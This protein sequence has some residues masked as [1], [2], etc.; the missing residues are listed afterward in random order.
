MMQCYH[1]LEY[2][3]H[4]I[5]SEPK[6]KDDTILPPSQWPKSP[7]PFRIEVHRWYNPT[8]FSRIEVIG[9]VLNRSSRMIQ[10]YHI[11]EDWSL[12]IPFW[13]EVQGWCNPA[14]FWGTKASGYLYEPNFKDDAI[15]LHSLGPKSPDLFWTDV[16][17][18]YNP[19]SFSRIK[20]TRSLLNKIPGMI[21][22]LL[23]LEDRGH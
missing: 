2:W 19:S 1:I 10:Y 17:G 7:D 12:R 3:S 14:T 21:Q 11:L 9:S 13:T 22:S 23:I 4:R 20:V 8:T 15:P 16:R 6:F 18:W 5:H